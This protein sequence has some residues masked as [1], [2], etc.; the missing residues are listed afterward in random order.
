MIGYWDSWA[1]LPLA[2]VSP[3]YDVV[4]ISFATGSGPDAAIMKFSPNT[5]TA[6]QIT[7]DVAVLRARGTKVLISVGGGGGPHTQLLNDDDL[8]NFVTSV[9][10]IV[11]KYKLDGLDL[12]FEDG[13]FAV[14]EGD[15]DVFHPT[16]PTIVNMITA[17]HQLRDHYGDSFMITAPPESEA[18]NGYSFY[19][20][21]IGPDWT[22]AY[23][24]FLS[25]L[26]G[27][28]DVLTFVAPQYYNAAP[29][30][31]LDNNEYKPGSPDFDV[32][33]AD[34]M[35]NGCMLV[36]GQYFPPIK[37][38]Q[39]AIG[40]PAT[41]I[42]DDSYLT[43]ARVLAAAEY[44]GSGVSY[45]GKYRLSRPDGYPDFQGVMTWDI[46]S[47]DHAKY[48]LADTL[49][50]YLHSL[51]NKATTIVD[52]FDD[53][54]IPTTAAGFTTADGGLSVDSDPHVL[55]RTADST[56]SIVY[57]L[58]DIV[59][60]NLR[61]YGVHAIDDISFFA[62]TDGTAWT[63]IPATAGT[64]ATTF[65]AW[66]RY[67]I[68]PAGTL[69]S[70]TNYLKIVVTGPTG[71]AADPS[72]SQ[73]SISYT[74]S[75]PVEAPKPAV[76]ASIFASSVNGA[77]KVTW[78]GVSGASAYNVYRIGADGLEPSTPIATVPSPAYVDFGLNSGTRY[79]YRVAAVS[80]SGTS[81]RSTEASASFI[82]EAPYSK[83]AAVP[84]IVHVADFDKGGPSIAYRTGKSTPPIYRPDGSG[85][86]KCADTDGAGN[87][88]D[89]AAGAPGSWR[90][91]TVDAEAVGTYNIALRV[92]SEAGGTL[93]LR[94]LNG[95][96]ISAAI[97]VP[98]TGG[99]Q[100]WSTVQ[101]TATLMA[102]RQTIQLYDDAGGVAV[103]YLRFENQAPAVPSAL[104]AATVPHNGGVN[105]TW[106]PSSVGAVSY[107]V[108]RGD[109]P[110]KEDYTKPIA[111]APGFKIANAVCTTHD[112]SAT[113][114]ATYYY[115]VKAVNGA[116]VSPPSNEVTHTLAEPAAY[117]GKPWPVPGVI[118]FSDYDTG[119]QGSGFFVNNG[120]TNQ[121]KTYRTD[122]VSIE[123]CGDK[124]TIGNGYDV[125]WSNGGNWLDYTVDVAQAGTYSATF[126]ISA[127]NAGSQL[128]LQDASA[129]NLTGVITL[130]G[131]GA[132]QKWT[133]VT[134]PVTLKA[135][136]QDIYLYE[137]SG[138]FNLEYMSFELASTK[139][140]E[141][142][143]K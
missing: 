27:T 100:K 141:A 2:K 123:P 17:M 44:I 92:A 50:P 81:A 109:A 9:E 84:G 93:H 122:A 60:F 131:T 19:G 119:G 23:G 127:E 108:Y 101:T 22:S 102:G 116:G 34:L 120:T 104:S 4:M 83:P 82:V 40:V 55:V 45:G 110:G 68:I 42:G 57:H 139:G 95:L 63:S 51:S 132:W 39:M 99:T 125:G 62:S 12:D 20:N 126:R 80:P 121:G 49:V 142:M 118:N 77:I 59:T 140:Q 89:M 56:A 129:T 28:R 58:G 54:S 30:Y 3:N 64:K 7:T 72:L 76:P 6:D 78:Q 137:D 86:E 5:E 97:S 91:Y 103:E 71:L 98:S 138:G 18:M 73:I 111:T 1:R 124:P 35:L 143:A 66:G 43:P 90:N 16:T 37:P 11:D 96:P 67:N 53:A 15:N 61:A 117:Q 74:G 106:K 79:Y 33:Q 36:T 8:K 13:I 94:A 136:K 31:G 21:K 10:G 88:F 105:L 107:A 29:Y 65:D 135:G 38:S 52:H 48:A 24:G 70:K 32:S 75:S 87:G 69:P 128:H 130:P 134:V 14:D 112:P 47:D 115:T 133:S 85:L 114:G 113:F 46:N 26:N 25:F 41:P